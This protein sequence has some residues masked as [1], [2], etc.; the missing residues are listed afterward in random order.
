MQEEDSAGSYLSEVPRAG[1]VIETNGQRRRQGLGKG[2]GESV[3]D[4]HRV[5][6]GKMKSHEDRWWRWPPNHPLKN[7]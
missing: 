7:G 4:G 2:G 6:A 1:K 3:C 5:S